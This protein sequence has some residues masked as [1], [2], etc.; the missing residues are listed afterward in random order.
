MLM[1]VRTNFRRMSD[2]ANSILPESTFYQVV[3]FVHCHLSVQGKRKEEDHY[4][5]GAV[6][7]VRMAQLCSQCS[8]QFQPSFLPASRKPLILFPHNLH[9]HPSLFLR[10][11]FSDPIIDTIFTIFCQYQRPF[12]LDLLAFALSTKLDH[13]D[14]FIRNL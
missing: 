8:R 13:S 10:T 2:S 12:S 1:W 6:A 5:Q 11:C 4:K 3:A 14:S 9:H 7:K